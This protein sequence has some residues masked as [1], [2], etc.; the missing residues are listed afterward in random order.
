MIQIIYSPKWFYGKDIIIDSISL[1]V[2]LLI[3][4]FS[5]KYYKIRRNK[6]YNF[7][8]FSF[9]LIALSFLFKILTNFTIYYKVLETHDL[10]IVTLTY[11]TI[12]VSEILFYI[13]FLAYRLLMLIGLYMLYSI[14]VKQPKSNILLITFFILTSTYFSQSSYYLF[15]LTALI[16]LI[17]ITV[18]YYTNY[19]TTKNKSTKFVA[20][21]FGIITISHL[22]SIFA[23]ISTRFYVIAELIQLMGFG[24]LLSSFLMVLSHG[25]KKD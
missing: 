6:N 2:L 18:H 5:F 21:S 24:F 25:R 15:H 8:G 14:Y 16:L 4:F 10:G 7:L 13:G 9:C 22:F 17:L 23:N 12:K 1:L 20:S 19:F 3:A 11:Q